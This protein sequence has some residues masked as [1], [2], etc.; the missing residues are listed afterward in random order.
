MSVC[1]GIQHFYIVEAGNNMISGILIKENTNA[2]LFFQKQ[3]N[4]YY[5]DYNSY[6]DIEH[7]E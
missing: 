6:Q 5:R 1:D 2:I 3:E 4:H 7:A